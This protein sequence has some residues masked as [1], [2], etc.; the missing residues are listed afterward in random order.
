MIEDAEDDELPAA[1]TSAGGDVEELSEDEQHWTR[2]LPEEEEEEEASGG[3]REG[4]ATA[5]TRARP[6]VS[7]RT[8]PVSSE[9]LVTAFPSGF[10]AVFHGPGG[11]FILV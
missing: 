4:A 8:R 6:L 3:Q 10:T 1:P 11:A 7:S 2:A 9:S 5:K